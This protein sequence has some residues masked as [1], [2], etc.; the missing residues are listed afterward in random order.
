MMKYLI[1]ALGL[2]EWEAQFVSGLSHP[3]FGMQV[4]R[5]CVDGVDIR[6]AIQISECQGVLVS[7]ATPRINQDLIAELSER[8][9]KLIAITTDVDRWQDLG[10]S[11][12]IELDS[13]NPLSA[14]KQVSELMRDEPQA[15]EPMSEPNGLLIAVAG[16]GGA[17]GR[18][19]T[20]KELGWQL[21]KMGN[22]TCM[23]DA[24]TYGPSLDQ[25]LGYEPNQNGLLELC[26]SIERKSSNL[27]THFDL[28]PMASENLS[29]VS[30]LPRISR[31]TDLRVSTLREL[32]Q[33]SRE[34]FDVVIADVGAVLEID[35]SLMHETSLP[36][37]HAASLTALES[38]QVSI[39]CARADSIGITRL[40]RGYLEFHELFAKSEVHV[41]LWGVTNDSESKDVRA[42]V[43]RH[44]GIESIFET[45]YDF[46]VMRKALTRN[47]FVSCLDSK[48]QVAKEFESIAKMLQQNLELQTQS[49]VRPQKQ[50]RNLLKRAA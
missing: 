11:H 12:C 44:T 31:W 7:D 27:Q 24:D 43:S 46:D 29:F 20:V 19:T 16:F 42:A 2:V 6:A 13:K 15:I 5:R 9:I 28:L 39:L 45:A 48:N 18:T 33:K 1:A 4:Q 34:T 37:R 47:T 21:S 40:V 10:A 8:K 17:C 3:M 32:W 49:K 38:A 25:E 35:H 26:R 36:R 30:G 14:I 41:V 50:R 22:R 23:V